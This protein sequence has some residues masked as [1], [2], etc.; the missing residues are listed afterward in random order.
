MADILK[1]NTDPAENAAWANI[2]EL[3]N[4]KDG[5]RREAAV[6]T[7]T[8]NNL[9]DYSTYGFLPKPNKGNQPALSVGV[10]YGNSNSTAPNLT[11]PPVYSMDNAG[12]TWH[13]FVRE[14][15]NNKA[16]PTFKR[17]KT[18]VVTASIRKVP[19]GSR[20]GALRAR[21]SAGCQER[22]GP[23]LLVRQYLDRQPG[24]PRCPVVVAVGRQLL[25][26]ARGGLVQSVGD[27]QDRG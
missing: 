13:A 11:N 17:P 24:E 21:H 9:K 23:V 19:S 2:F 14:Y 25:G 4:T 3:R 10:W 12:R 16:A 27:G 26:R 7:G 8:T 15:M 6:K 20:T 5:S 18:G 1:G 22:G